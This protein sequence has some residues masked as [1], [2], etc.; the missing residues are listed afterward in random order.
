[1]IPADTVPISGLSQVS[2]SRP[3]DFQSVRR[4]TSS[5]CGWPVKARITTSAYC[6]TNS[7]GLM[8]RPGRFLTAVRSR[9]A[10]ES[11]GPVGRWNR[12]QIFKEKKR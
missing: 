11:G 1:M 6:V 9:G 4:S 8:I 2:L 5:G 12:K 7:I 10:G 3:A